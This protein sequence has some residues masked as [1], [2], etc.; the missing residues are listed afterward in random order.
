NGSVPTMR[1]LLHLDPRP[2]RFC[3]GENVYDPDALGYV[4]PEIGPE[5]DCASPREAFLF[6]TTAPGNANAGHD[7]PWSPEELDDGRRADLE[8]LLAYMKTL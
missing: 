4:A 8:A 2:S 6:D 5:D 7:Y 1:Q 3:R